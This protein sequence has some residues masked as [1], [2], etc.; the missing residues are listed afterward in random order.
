MISTFFP[1]D[2]QYQFLNS[3]LTAAAVFLAASPGVWSLLFWFFFC[4]IALKDI[5]SYLYWFTI[6]ICP[7]VQILLNC[8]W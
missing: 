7:V 8:A 4:L 3:L 6:R 1:V 5:C 2:A